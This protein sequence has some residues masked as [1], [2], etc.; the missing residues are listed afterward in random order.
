M[1]LTTV[2]SDTAVAM[3]VSF[4]IHALPAMEPSSL[5]RALISIL[6]SL[7]VVTIDQSDWLDQ[8]IGTP[9]PSVNF[10]GLSRVEIHGQCSFVTDS[11]VNRLMWPELCAMVARFAQTEAMKAEG[12]RGL[13][14][15]VQPV[16]PVF[17]REALTS[18]VWRRYVPPQY[19]NGY[20]FRDIAKRTHVSKSTLYRAADWLDNEFDGLELCA[21]R[22]LEETFVP[23]GVCGRYE[24]PE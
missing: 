15:Y 9:S 19:R 3:H 6:E 7:D 5:R 1:M 4:L 8:L 13:V 23:H 11:A 2:F 18:L 14:N 12:V 20:S 22:R 16:S 10:A 24:V 17:N 21:L